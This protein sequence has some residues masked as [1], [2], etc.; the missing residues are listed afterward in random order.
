MVMWW[1]KIVKAFI[2][3][4]L[5]LNTDSLSRLWLSTFMKIYHGKY[6]VC[7][8]VLKQVNHGKYL[9]YH[10]I[11]LYTIIYHDI[12]W[13]TMI[14]HGILWDTMVYFHKGCINIQDKPRH[15]GV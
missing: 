15:K 9:I 13:H 10:G 2:R 12:P 6:M 14:Y 4:Q 7:H 8:C 1:N 5:D 3:Q 11:P